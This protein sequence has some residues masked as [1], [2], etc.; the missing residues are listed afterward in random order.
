MTLCPS[1]MPLMSMDRIYWN[2]RFVAF[3]ATKLWIEL[4]ILAVKLNQYFKENAMEKYI[5]DD[6]FQTVL[7][8]I[9]YK[10]EGGDVESIR[11]MLKTM[12]EDAEKEE[13]FI[14]RTYIG[15]VK[16]KKKKSRIADITGMLEKMSDKQVENVHR[17][18]MDELDEPNHEAE[19]LE[20]I[21]KLS[22]RN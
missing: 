3:V 9:A 17:Y 19:A 4:R 20:A 14:D 15:E 18:T 13:H 2:N 22:R 12:I 10:L 8:D 6:E 16:A 11:S 7:E 5:T 1:T 21:M